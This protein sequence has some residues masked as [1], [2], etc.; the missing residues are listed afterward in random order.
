MCTT[1]LSP[2]ARTGSRRRPGACRSRRSRRGPAGRRAPRRCRRAVRG[3]CVGLRCVRSWANRVRD[4]I[5]VEV[6]FSVFRFSGNR[7]TVMPNRVDSKTGHPPLLRRAIAFIH[8][9]AHHD[10]T[11]SDIA[12][13]VN[14]TPR[15]VQYTFR[16]NL[17]HD[18]A[19]IPASRPARPRAPRAASRRSV[20]RHRDGDRRVDGGSVMPADS[21][22]ST[23]RRSERHRARRCAV[24]RATALY[25]HIGKKP[26]RVKMPGCHP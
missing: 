26:S 4:V 1:K 18:P 11:L 20:H 17:G 23:S 16:R 25:R 7:R 15:S 12:A 6:R 19:G 2:T 3:W 5:W 10:I 24:G 22:E 8:D 21:A 13:A 9:N 14:V